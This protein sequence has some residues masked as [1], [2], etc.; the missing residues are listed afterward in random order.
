MEVV[1]EEVDVDCGGHENEPEV[2]PV[3]EE[4]L[5]DPEQEVSVQVTLVHLVQHDHVVPRQTRVR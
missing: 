2:L 3:L 5:D 1:L 4:A